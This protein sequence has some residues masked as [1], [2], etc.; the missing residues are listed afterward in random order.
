MFFP[1]G[2]RTLERRSFSINPIHS[3]KGANGA[4]RQKSMDKTEIGDSEFPT[5][6]F[7]PL[8]TFS[9][10][11]CPIPT[12]RKTMLQ[13]LFRRTYLT[14][15]P[16][17]SKSMPLLFRYSLSAEPLRP[18]HRRTKAKASLFFDEERADTSNIRRPRKK[19]LL[20]VAN[21]SMRRT[22]EFQ[23]RI[24]PVMNIQRQYAHG[25][26][27]LGCRAI[28]SAIFSVLATCVKN[29]QRLRKRRLLRHL[30]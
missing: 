14:F 26:P 18:L 13:I 16:S 21:R 30:S 19:P 27:L 28:S 15:K 11:R 17:F 8:R 10:R 3:A 2:A 4:I 9:S 23:R 25:T 1:S 12:R 20:I 7:L 29:N 6:L 24:A 5:L 22:P